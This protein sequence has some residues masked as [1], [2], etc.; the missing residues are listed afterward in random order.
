MSEPDQPPPGWR[1]VEPGERI[2][3]SD[4]EA[5]PLT[6]GSLFAGIGG[7]DL[8]LE[9]AG[10]ECR[11][12]VEIDPYATR[13]L[14]KHW[15]HV[16]RWGNIKTFLPDTASERRGAWGPRRT[17]AR[18]ERRSL[19]PWAAQWQ[20]DLIA[21]GFPCQ[22]ISYAGK[23]AGLSGERSGLWF[24]FARVVRTLRPRFLI[25]ENVPA[26]LTRGID[27]V[28][29]TLATLGYDAEWTCLPAA[30]VG[31]PHIRDRVFILAHAHRPEWWAIGS[32]RCEVDD[33]EDGIQ[34]RR[35]EDP[36]WS[37]VSGQKMADLNTDCRRLQ[38]GEEPHGEQRPGID[39]THRNDALRLRDDLPNAQRERIRV[40]GRGADDLQA[41]RVQE[42]TWERQRIRPDAGSTRCIT[43]GRTLS[44]FR[45]TTGFSQWGRDPAEEPESG[46]GGM[47]ARLS[48]GMDGGLTERHEA[49]GWEGLYVPRV[50]SDIPHRVDRLR[51]LGNAV[52]PQVAE[53][54]G[55]RL[56]A[57]LPAR[58]LL[59]VP[60]WCVGM[61]AESAG[62]RVYRRD[63]EPSATDHPARG[64]EA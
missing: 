52:V 6:F 34:G 58:R 18:R 19:S 2:E 56:I 42:T 3:P 61:P 45:D 10:L 27:A 36:G 55:R 22:D 1:V 50:A 26:L 21:G 43:D 59:P 4:V 39:G 28:L 17:A 30:A 41:G 37:G 63:G 62:N 24:E 40:Q 57:S 11:W 9:R 8:G 15:P 5:A 31:A 32:G 29:G 25:V 47:V 54:I 12:Q 13:V 20:V 7:L 49:M 48:A 46:M 33:T 51:G 53:W 14:A 16:R 64:D 38:G 23:G 35:E 60:D 44:Q